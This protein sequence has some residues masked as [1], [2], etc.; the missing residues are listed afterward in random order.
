MEKWQGSEVERE[1]KSSVDYRGIWAL[2]EETEKSRRQPS[3]NVH[4][5]HCE[6]DKRCAQKM[7]C[8]YLRVLRWFVI[9]NFIQVST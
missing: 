8:S 2:I 5:K 1:K 6:R 3:R 9:M 4:K 7:P